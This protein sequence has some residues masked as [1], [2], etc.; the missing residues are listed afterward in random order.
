MGFRGDLDDRSAD[1]QTLPNRQVGFAQIKVNKELI[2]S[3]RP[4]F[5]RLGNQVNGPCVHYIQLH[6]WVRC[7]ICRA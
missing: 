2:A 5:L 1:P 7:A 3:Q 6:I 4:A